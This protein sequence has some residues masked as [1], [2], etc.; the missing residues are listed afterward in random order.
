MSAYRAAALLAG[1]TVLAQITYPL[2]NG[3]VR[4]VVTVLVVG[5]FAA[6]CI[7]HAVA[8]YGSRWAAG[9]VVSTA[10]IGFVVE[11]IGTATGFPFGCYGYDVGRL[12]PSV[13][14]VPLVVPFA[15]TAG[16]Y[17]VWT[18]ASILFQRTPVRV[19]AVPLGALGWDLYLDP[20][21]VADGQWT[22]CV[23]DSGLPGIPDIP[24]TNYL[25]WLAVALVMAVAIELL[26]R[27]ATTPRSFA[28]PVA[29]FYWTWLGSSLAHAVFL[30][31]PH[32][33]YSAIYG[34]VVM[35]LL[36]VPLTRRLFARL[37]GGT[38]SV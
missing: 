24:Y 1:A 16:I 38:V 10:G 34:L 19:A 18:V 4:D 11:T 5:L 2:T 17:C 36:G 37:R 15:W 13:A 3:G 29:L 7:T 22:W 33:K 25:G 30:D 14:D 31:G 28:V 12:G 8:A 9:F 27:Q 26:P 21:M 35:G 32:L 20:Q 23:T 6:A